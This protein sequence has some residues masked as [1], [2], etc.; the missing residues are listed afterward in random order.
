MKYWILEI[1]SYIL[2]FEMLLNQIRVYHFIKSTWGMVSEMQEKQNKKIKLVRA[3]FIP[4]T[5]SGNFTWFFLI[6]P[7]N[8]LTDK[9]IF[10]LQ[11]KQ[12]KN[13]DVW[14]M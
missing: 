11:V 6:N 4:E 1:F 3:Y 7:P 14:L 10:I 12:L 5:L 2:L 8:R 9:N 13:W